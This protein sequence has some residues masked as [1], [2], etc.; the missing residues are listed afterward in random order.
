MFYFFEKSS[1]VS[2]IGEFSVQQVHEILKLNQ[3]GKKPENFSEFL[4]TKSIQKEL[5]YDNVVGQDELTRFDAVFK[6]KKNKKYFRN[7]RKS[8]K[9]RDKK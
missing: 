7:K 9:K 2:S 6:K 5:D 3:K 4:A 8:S 1:G